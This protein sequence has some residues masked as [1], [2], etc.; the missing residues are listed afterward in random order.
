MIGCPLTYAVSRRA[1]VLTHSLTQ[2]ESVPV[3]KKGGDDGDD[4]LPAG[5]IAG[6]VV[7]V[8]VGLSL[9]VGNPKAVTLNLNLILALTL[10]SPEPKP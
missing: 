10:T 5:A 6:I 4:D 3:V 1:G 9:V 7:G 8:L 2:V